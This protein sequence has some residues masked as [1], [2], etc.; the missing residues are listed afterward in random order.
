MTDT[1]IGMTPA[2]IAGLFRPFGQIDKTLSRRY[3]GLGI[4][5]AYVHNMARLLGGSVAVA[6]PPEGGSRFTVTL[7][8]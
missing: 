4:G 1:G 7:P 6:S 8:Y 3:E 2:E 5:L